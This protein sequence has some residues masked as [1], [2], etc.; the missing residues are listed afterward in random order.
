MKRVSLMVSVVMMAAVVLS[1]CG[2]GAAGGG[3]AAAAKAWFEA[4]SQLDMAKVTDLTCEQQKQTIQ[5]SLAFLGGGGDVDL[6]QL[7]ELFKIDVS[8]LT[9]TEKSV[10]GNTAVVTVSG[11]MKVEAFGQSQEQDVNNEDLPMVNEGGAWKVCAA[12]LPGE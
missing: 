3:A 9:F 8:G 7:K 4:F 12:S 11:K 10:T 6:N 2:G 5:E 1:A